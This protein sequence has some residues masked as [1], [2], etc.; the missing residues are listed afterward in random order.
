MMNRCIREDQWDWFTVF[1]EFGAPPR[2]VL[3]QIVAQ[4]ITLRKAAIAEDESIY[5]A[6]LRDSVSTN[7]LQ[8]LHVYQTD[9]SNQVYSEGAGWIYIL[10]TREQPRVLKIG[11]TDRSVVQRVTEINAATG[12]LVPWAARRVYRFRNAGD[13]EAEIHRRLSAYRLRADRE[14]FELSLGQAVETIAAYLHVKGDVG[15]KAN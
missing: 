7:V 9:L 1:T 4:I 3:R 2:D 11:R 10:S 15:S 8:L 5:L 6:S 14:F 12:V 13:A